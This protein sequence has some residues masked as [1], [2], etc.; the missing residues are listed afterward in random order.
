MVILLDGFRYIRISIFSD[1]PRNKNPNAKS[2]PCLRS[3]AKNIKRQRIFCFFFLQQDVTYETVIEC[4]SVSYECVNKKKNKTSSTV[5]HYLL[6][7]PGRVSEHARTGLSSMD[8]TTSTNTRAEGVSA[9]SR[10][11]SCHSAGG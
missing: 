2:R 10:L 6:V 3:T 8:Q 11:M 5:S 4:L 1:Q 7:R 9:L